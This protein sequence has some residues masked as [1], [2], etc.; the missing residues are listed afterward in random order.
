[1]SKALSELLNLPLSKCEVALKRCENDTEKATDYLLTHEEENEVFWDDEESRKPVEFQRWGEN[2]KQVDENSLSEIVAA[3]IGDGVQYCDDSFPASDN[4]LFF[5]GEDARQVWTCHD[6]NKTNQMPSEDVLDQYRKQNPSREQIQEF[7]TYI[8]R[9]NPM[10]AMTMQSNPSSA[11]QLMVQSMSGGTPAPL[12]P[13]KCMHCNGEFALGVLEAKPTLWLR[14]SELRDEVTATY[15]SGAPWKLFRSDPRADDVKQGAVGNCWFLGALSIMAHQNPQLIRSLFP[16]NQEYSDQGVYLVRLCKDGFWRNVIIDDRLPCNRNKALTY[17]SAA[18]RQLWAPLV[19]KAAAKLSTCYEGLHSGTISEAFSL[20]TGFATDRQLL[21]V[22]KDDD[23]SVTDVWWARLVSAHSAGYLIGLACSEKRS[24]SKDRP[25]PTS[26]ELHALGLQAPHAYIVLDTHELDDGTRLVHLG[27]PWG[28]RSP[29]TWK[30]PWG[31]ASA[32]YRS[33]VNQGR[34]PR[35]LND[36]ASNGQFWISWTELVRC[37]A[38]LEICRTDTTEL[39]NEVRARGWLPAATGL[40]DY[41][42]LSLPTGKDQKVRCDISLYQESHAIRES[43]KG[44][45]TTCV[46][47]GFVVVELSQDGSTILKQVASVSRTAQAEISL[48]VFLTSGC[49]YAIIPLSFCNAFKV[50]HRKVVACTRINKAVGN[51]SLKKT[52]QSV[53]LLQQAI[54]EYCLSISGT[55]IRELAPG[56]E[57]LVTKDNAGAIITSENRTCNVFYTVSVDADD[58][59]NVTSSRGFSGATIVNDSI[60]PARKRILMI[61]S[62]NPGFKSYSLSVSVAVGVNVHSQSESY[63][64]PI[65]ADESEKDLLSMMDIHMSTKTEVSRTIP[66]SSLISRTNDIRSQMMIMQIGAERQS[67]MQRLIESYVS[68]GIDPSD[69]QLVAEEEVDNKYM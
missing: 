61:L 19:E 2:M 26:S 55:P 27:N 49:V 24:L 67:E 1:M 43:S 39:D 60:G 32:E 36:V 18:R 31:N 6:C 4:S 16:F 29:N 13:L 58:S 46:D 9:T 11:V 64:P 10:L 8:S 22:S 37:F 34:L 53:A 59:S 40:G 57:Y 12:P 28:D 63:S 14:P 65:H 56:L 69:A 52:P 3:C 54:H 48:E 7:F 20:L 42:H 35:D 15:G 21:V 45:S 44:A 66:F 68:A 33:A 30:G 47:L 41:F 17:T 62:A 5:S 25:F 38:S 23:D 51:V 50:E